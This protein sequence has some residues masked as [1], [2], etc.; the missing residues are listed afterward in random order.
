L[1]VIGILIGAHIEFTLAGIN[2]PSERLIHK[3]K[4]II[5]MDLEEGSVV[6]LSL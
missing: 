6:G 1:D 3:W 4:Y 2:I 5:I